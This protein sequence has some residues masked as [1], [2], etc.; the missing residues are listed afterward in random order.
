MK[1]REGR[2]DP[3]PSLL[4]SQERVHVFPSY[5]CRPTCHT[6]TLTS[7]AHLTAIKQIVTRHLAKLNSQ[8]KRLS[9]STPLAR[10]RTLYP[11]F[12]EVHTVQ[13]RCSQHACTLTPYEYTC[14]NPTPMST[15]E[16]LSTGRFG[17][18]RNH[19][20]RLVVD[21]NVAY[22]LMHNAVGSSHI[23][24]GLNMGLVFKL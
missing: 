24:G 1:D 18:S 16:G 13:H 19:H 14:A 4:I 22:H 7:W 5:R 23:E 2:R 3:T 21:G 6:P 9:P 20:W 12:F 10:A 11:H 17:D 15:S 8:R